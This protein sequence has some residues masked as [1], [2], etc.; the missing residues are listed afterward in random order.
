MEENKYYIA[1]QSAEEHSSGVIAL[2]QKEYEAVQK[3]LKQIYSF[4]SGY[5]GSCGIKEKSFTTE[6]EA[7]EYYYDQG[8]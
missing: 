8:N 5:C 2:T 1:Y 3:F 7:Q 4:S 6:E